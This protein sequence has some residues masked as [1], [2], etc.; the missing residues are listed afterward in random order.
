[1][2]AKSASYNNKNSII[3]IVNYNTKINK[4]YN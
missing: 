4:L 3:F 1:M 2:Y